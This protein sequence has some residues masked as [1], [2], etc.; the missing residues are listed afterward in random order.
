MRKSNPFSRP[1]PP[2][3]SGLSDADAR[4]QYRTSDP[5]WSS[6][7]SSANPSSLRHRSLGAPR[8]TKREWSLLG[9]VV[10]F[11]SFVRLWG[12]SSPSSVVSVTSPISLSLSPPIS[13]TKSSAARSLTS[14]LH[15]ALPSHM[16]T[17][18]LPFHPDLT[19]CT[20]EASRPRFVQITFANRTHRRR[21][22]SAVP[23]HVCSSTVCAFLFLTVY[24]P[25]LFHGR[26][27]SPGQA[28]HHLRCLARWL[29]GWHR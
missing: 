26:P 2:V 22:R 9:A 12:I 15:L 6:S 5:A 21:F 29:P 23:S 7:P 25:N 4:L 20:L 28:T 3:S 24:S 10:V 18:V 16:L 11:A 27:S 14:S 1:A 19:K 8:I 13:V 17:G